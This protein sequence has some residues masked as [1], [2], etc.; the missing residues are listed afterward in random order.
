MKTSF[1]Q[2]RLNLRV[3][4]ADGIMATPW[5]IV[6]LPGSFLVASLLNLTFKVGPV[7][8]GVI[9]SMPALANAVSIFLLPWMGRF[10]N[11]RELSLTLAMMNTGIWLCGILTIALLP[12]GNPNQAG[13]FFAL[14]YLLLAFT[15]AL[16]GVGWTSWVTAFIPQRIRGRY[17]ARRNIFTNFSTLIFMGVSMG[18]LSLFEGQR[19]LYVCL[20]SLAVFGRIVSVLLQHQIRS[21]D[22]TGGRVCSDT[23]AKDLWQLRKERPLLRYIFFG[24]V[25]GFFM[26]FNGPTVTLYAFELLKATPAQFTAFSIVAT[27]CGTLSVR[28]W[29][30]LI[31]R[32]GAIPVL[33]ITT[34]AWRL[35]DFGWIVLN[36]HTK[37]L[38]FLVWAWG[39]TMG[40]GFMLANFILLLKLIPENNRSA[41]ISL[42]MTLVS[43]CAAV[44]PVLAG[45]WL[46][47]SSTL[48]ISPWVVYR[49]SLAVGFT[50][51]LL[52]A[53][54]LLGLKEPK[55]H[56]DR[57]N[58]PGALRT[59]RQLS[60][61]QG[62][63]FFGNGNFVIRLTKQI[64]N[65]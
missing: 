36:E 45:W 30:E 47:S 60:V 17:M 19:W 26:A 57:N 37:L 58:I 34:I 7:W 14:F 48:E 40:T 62:L 39:G 61:N 32:H 52:S 16:S 8:F 23:W 11:V 43:I 5:A 56:P 9:I 27:I 12:A 53:L 1:S 38:L 21:T 24:S 15:S 13:L 22:P 28:I 65:K 46:D 64:K 31:D 18:L 59:L 49:G 44:A 20:I 63:A 6:S 50:G 54:L 10:M 29:G 51:C 3:C 4:S 25:A 42:N 35:G 2:T 33:I 41:G 55:T